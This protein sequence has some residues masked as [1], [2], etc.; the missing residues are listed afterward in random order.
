MNFRIKPPQT[1]WGVFLFIFPLNI[2][3]D[4]L[5]HPSIVKD[6]LAGVFAR[7]WWELLLLL[8]YWAVDAFIFALVFH[9]IFRRI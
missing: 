5:F 3:V 8:A 4:V 6:I 2:A 7:S 9:F 1:F